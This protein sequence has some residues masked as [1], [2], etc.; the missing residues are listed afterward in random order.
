[1]NPEHFLAEFL[2]TFALIFAI[3][4]TG[5][6]LAIGATLAASIFL[7]GGISG[8]NLNPAVSLAM[9]LNGKMELSKFVL[10]ILTQFAG[11]A[12]AVYTYNLTKK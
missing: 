9:L 11:A 3:L 10:Y 5:N 7:L 6:F 12:V 4:G 2:G 8:A 1:M